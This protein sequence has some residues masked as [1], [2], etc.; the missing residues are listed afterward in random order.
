MYGVPN[1]H[2]EI[3]EYRFSRGADGAVMELSKENLKKAFP[4]NED[5]QQKIDQIFGSRLELTA[6]DGG[7]RMY[8][9]NW[10]YARVKD[11]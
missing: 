10:L 7:H 8:V 6:Y 1:H 2:E 3:V 11:Q 9:V 5:F 4:E